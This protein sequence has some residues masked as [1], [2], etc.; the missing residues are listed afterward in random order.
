[1]QIESEYVDLCTGTNSEQHDVL[2]VEEEIEE[3]MVTSLIQPEEVGTIIDAIG[4]RSSAGRVR[5]PQA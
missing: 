4:S 3:T 1:M 2:S 5:K